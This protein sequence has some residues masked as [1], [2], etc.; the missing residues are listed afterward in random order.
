MNNTY[1]KIT[2]SI[3]RPNGIPFPSTVPMRNNYDKPYLPTSSRSKI[4][5]RIFIRKPYGPHH[6][7][8]PHANTM[9]LYG[10]N[11]SN[12]CP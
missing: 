11:R 5:N 4:L 1:Y 10:S 2:Q 9:K 3:N 8:S 7:S 6:G 12:N